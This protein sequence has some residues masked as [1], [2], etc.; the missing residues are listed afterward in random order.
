[1]LRP[2]STMVSRA[3]VAILLA[4]CAGCGDSGTPSAADLAACD[5]IT[6]SDVESVTGASTPAGSETKGVDGITTCQ[7]SA[8]DGSHSVLVRVSPKIGDQEHAAF[9]FSD[10]QSVPGLGDDATFAERAVPAG[11]PSGYDPG[12]ALSALD[13]KVEISIFYQGKGDR[14]VV[15]KALAKAAL[16]R[17]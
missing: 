5:L 11:E 16:A 1:M 7:Y 6:A 15:S 17:L 9:P 4:A 3:T 10:A 2:G 12:S 14:L 8:P 13:G